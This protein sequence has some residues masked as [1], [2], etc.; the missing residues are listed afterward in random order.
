MASR[1]AAGVAADDPIAAPTLRE[2][3][4]VAGWGLAFWAGAQLASAVL[5]RNAT[6][7][8]AVQAV[9]AEWGAG[10]VGI[11]W[12]DPLAPLP[13]WKQLARRA[14]R[15]VALGGAVAALVVAAALAT[16]GAATAR[17]SPS[18]G[19]L[20]VGLVVA[21]LTAV[22]DELLLR[23]IVLRATRALLPWWAAL[24]ACGAA[25]AAARFGVDGAVGLA[26]GVEA[27]RGV[28]LGAVWVRDR[29]AWMAV[30]A[31]TAWRWGLESLAHGGLFDVRFAAEADASLQALGVLAL[32][33]A[34]AVVWSRRSPR[35]AAATG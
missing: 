9:L 21:V 26:L 19:L 3:W 28:A 34:A 6:A 18:V 11:S 2:A 1:G 29:G 27:L 13:T 25:A 22:R 17:S 12:S 14:G 31:S 5:A 35:A 4:K 7:L 30:G 20:A 10:R 16:G 24:L 23:G 8:V 33:A 15:G 32:A